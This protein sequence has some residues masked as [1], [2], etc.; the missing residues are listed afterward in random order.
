MTAVSASSSGTSAATA[1]PNTNSRMM[2]VSASAIRPT[3]ASMLPKSASSSFVVL[4]E[5]ISS[6]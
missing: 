6:T 1:E 5:P 2:R 4:T 3:L